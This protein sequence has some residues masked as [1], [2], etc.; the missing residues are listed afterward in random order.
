[1]FRNKLQPCPFCG[2]K[3][4]LISD[5]RDK[6]YFVMCSNIKCGVKLS[7]SGNKDE[8]IAKWNR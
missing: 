7:T 3:A 2:A 6:V 4:R 8:A 5:N 1:M